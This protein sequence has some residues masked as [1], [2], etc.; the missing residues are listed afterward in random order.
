MINDVKPGGKNINISIDNVTIKYISGDVLLN[1]IFGKNKNS[2]VDS[3]T[4]TINYY[5]KNY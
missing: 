3:V 5:Y 1:F 4:N 2:V